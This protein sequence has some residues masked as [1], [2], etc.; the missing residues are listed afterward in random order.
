VR[1]GLQ[2][3]GREVIFVEGSC[4]SGECEVSRVL[5]SAAVWLTLRFSARHSSNYPV[6]VRVLRAI[7]P[8][9]CVP[10]CC[11]RLLEFCGFILCICFAM[12][13]VLG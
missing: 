3:S 6:S 1:L 13:G 7:A 9:C 8:P 11:V 2:D 12:H 10:G 4:S 5:K